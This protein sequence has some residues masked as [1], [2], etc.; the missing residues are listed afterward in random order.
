[1]RRGFGFVRFFAT[2]MLLAIVGVIAY[3]VGWSDGVNTHLSAGT[4]VR[5]YFGYS[6]GLMGAG[7]GIFSLLAFFFVLFVVFGLLRLAF[8][9]RGMI[10]GG[11]G[12]GRGFYGPGR[13]FSSHGHGIPSGIEERMQEWHQRAHGEAPPAAPNTTPPPADQRTV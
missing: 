13:G 1:M 12:A 3:N 4:E 5:P 7:F 10:G 11:W 6:A 9:G 2:V 8:F